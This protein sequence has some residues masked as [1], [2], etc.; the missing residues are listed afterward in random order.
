M[1]PD[2]ATVSPRIQTSMG[3]SASMRITDK[4]S[5]VGRGQN[6]RYFTCCRLTLK[7]SGSMMNLVSGSVGEIVAGSKCGGWI[8]GPRRAASERVAS[9]GVRPRKEIEKRLRDLTREHNP[10][11]GR[12]CPDVRGKTEKRC[13]VHGDG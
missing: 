11:M 2:A 3:V 7:W 5:S 12:F 10:P 9:I 8:E 6:A 4:A 13:L 1:R